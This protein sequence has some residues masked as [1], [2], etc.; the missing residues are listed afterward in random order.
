MIVTYAAD[1]LAWGL[2]L[3]TNENRKIV[4]I[5]TQGENAGLSGPPVDEI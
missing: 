1:L 2:L 4:Y 3:V 5:R